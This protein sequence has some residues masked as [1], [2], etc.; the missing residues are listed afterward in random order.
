MYD[1]GLY[2]ANNLPSTLEI[3]KYK[4]RGAALIQLTKLFFWGKGDVCM[5]AKP[6]GLLKQIC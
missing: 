1:V 4:G 2:Y 6:L 3:H 5:Q